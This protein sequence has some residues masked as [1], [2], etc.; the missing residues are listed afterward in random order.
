MAK[1]CAVISGVYVL[2]IPPSQGTVFVLQRRVPTGTVVGGRIVPEHISR[3]KIGMNSPGSFMNSEVDFLGSGGCAVREREGFMRY[4]DFGVGGTLTIRSTFLSGGIPAGGP[5]VARAVLREGEVVPIHLRDILDARQISR[6]RTNEIFGARKLEPPP[7]MER[8]VTLK[9]AGN[10]MLYVRDVGKIDIATININGS[11]VS[12]SFENRSE[13]VRAWDRLVGSD[14]RKY[15]VV[16]MLNNAAPSLDF[17]EID[18]DFHLLYDFFDGEPV[19]WLPRVRMPLQR[20]LLGRFLS[21]LPGRGDAQDDGEPPRKCMP[22][23]GGV[24]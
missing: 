12:F 21:L 10:G 22:L 8:T 4:S 7:V 6:A 18:R 2:G 15:F 11:P 3:L 1:L 23:V 17:E 24:T 19:R 16:W 14:D 5:L 13:Q 9:F 20:G